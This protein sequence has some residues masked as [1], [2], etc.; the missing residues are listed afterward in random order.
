MEDYADRILSTVFRVAV[1]PSR[2]TD[3]S[4]HRLS[5]LPSLSRELTEEGVPLKLSI[6]RLEEA[7]MEAAT[8]YPHERPLLEYLLPC[9]KRVTKALKVL[10]GPAPQKEGMLKEARRLCFSNCI[11]ALTMPELF[12]CA[13]SLWTFWPC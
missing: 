10:R 4:G 12:R 2:E 8:A 9:W 3:Q 13:S 6:D 1:D 5:F 11:F 7:I